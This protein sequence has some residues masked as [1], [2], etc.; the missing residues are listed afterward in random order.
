M[1]NLVILNLDCCVYLTQLPNGKCG[2]TKSKQFAKQLNK[3]QAE[4]WLKQLANGNGLKYLI[5]SA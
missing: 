5:K 1:N 4:L 3:E 2:W